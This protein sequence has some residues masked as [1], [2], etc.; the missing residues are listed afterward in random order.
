MMW[1]APELVLVLLRNSVIDSTIG[2]QNDVAR[3]DDTGGGDQLAI[4]GVVE[5][6]A[7]PGCAEVRICTN[8]YSAV[9]DEGAAAIAVGGAESEC[10]G[11]FLAQAAGA[12]DHA[13][14]VKVIAH[15]VKSV[16]VGQRELTQGRNAGAVFQRRIV[17]RDGAECTQ[18]AV[19][20]NP[21]DGTGDAGAAGVKV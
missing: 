10:A 19:G 11:A 21:D 17:H 12:T 2:S 7:G 3:G 14:E 6:D 1:T 15:R 9:T 5:G 16:G 20:T 8:L 13:S 18:V 4:A